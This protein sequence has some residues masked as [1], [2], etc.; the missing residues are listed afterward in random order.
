MQQYI[1]NDNNL[2]NNIDVSSNLVVQDNET[3]IKLE[4]LNS[5]VVDSYK[6]T[7]VDI[8]TYTNGNLESPDGVYKSDGTG[9]VRNSV[10]ASKTT[11][12]ADLGYKYQGSDIY[13][14]NEA[15]KVTIEPSYNNANATQSGTTGNVTIPSWANQVSYVLKGGGGGAGGPSGQLVN[16]GND[17]GWCVALG[18]AGGNGGRGGLRVGT[19][20][21]SNDTISY[22]VGSGGVGGQ[23][24]YS[25][26]D[27]RNRNFRIGGNDRSNTA[28]LG[29]TTHPD[30]TNNVNDPVG[31]GAGL[32][33]TSGGNTQITYEGVDYIASGGNP[34]NGGN[35]GHI[36]RRNYGKSSSFEGAGSNGEGGASGD[37][38]D[39]SDASLSKN[40]NGI[41][42]MDDYSN[43]ITEYS[44]SSITVKSG[45]T[46]TPPFNIFKI[47][48]HSD[49]RGQTGS[50]IDWG[51]DP[52]GNNWKA[53]VPNVNNTGPYYKFRNTSNYDDRKEGTRENYGEMGGQAKSGYPGSM[54]LWYRLGSN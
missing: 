36:Y 50:T 14:Y 16:W 7:N 18:C 31:A 17:S 1:D 15:K 33:G 34:G 5:G 26:W 45:G 51:R 52:G 11:V 40:D 39:A 25:F 42:T 43:S 10:Y 23:A 27:G 32:D 2:R 47:N 41:Y 37:I 20:N 28:F 35:F 13:P 12:G 21:K 30:H 44:N 19:I 53:D 9:T 46:A 6:K 4:T 54:E 3:N 24:G 48:G 38:R 29:R 22:T 8:T 49:G